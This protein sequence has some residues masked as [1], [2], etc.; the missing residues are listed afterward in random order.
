[1]SWSLT[2]H[3]HCASEEDERALVAKLN[4]VLSEPAAGTAASGFT[5][6]HHRGV[7]HGMPESERRAAPRSVKE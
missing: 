5:G 2:A 6:E 4:R 3:G 1:M 7:V